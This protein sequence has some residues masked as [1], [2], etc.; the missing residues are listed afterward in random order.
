M[1]FSSRV[2]ASVR[3]SAALSAVAAAWSPFAPAARAA[4][5][6]NPGITAS[7]AHFNPD[8]AAE[9]VFDARGR[10]Y[11]TSGNGAGAP[12]STDPE[13]GTW[14]NFDFYQPETIDTF[15]NRTRT[16]PAGFDVIEESRLIFSQDDTFDASDPFVTFSPTGFAGAGLVQR[17]AP[18]TA[19]Y[20]RWEVVRVSGQNNNT[21]S[22]Q[23][24]FMKS[25]AGMLPLPN[26]AVVGG[27][28]AFN[29]NYALQNAA[30]GNAG[31]D[32]TGNEYASQNGQANTF[33]D[34]DF[35]AATPI[36]GFDF[37]NREEDL[38]TGYDMIFSNTADFATELDRKSF[39]AS[40]NGNEVNSEVFD[41]VTARYVRLQA[42]QWAVNGNTG[43]SEIM[44]YTPVPEPGAAAVLGV[45]AFAT[46]RRRRA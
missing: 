31:R 13:D 41:P 18:Q 6:P 21:G 2:R 45:A 5:L 38:I 20:V 42:T 9:N 30:N 15:I 33:V 10:E 39:S 11:A 44:F 3:A 27:T 22:R 4:Q 12:L 43:V 32:G 35:G 19:Q 46:L 16:S 36:S 24:F 28:P 29:D 40:L 14:I 23:M 17:F 25:P 26:P 8:Y 7:A 34:F 37:L 1:V